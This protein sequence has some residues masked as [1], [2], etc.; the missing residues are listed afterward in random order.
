MLVEFNNIISSI[1]DNAVLIQVENAIAAGDV[2]L[3]IKL[4]GLDEATWQP[5]VEQIRQSYIVGGTTGAGQI[6]SIPIVGGQITMRF[7]GSNPRAENWIKTES[8]ALIVE[9]NNSQKEL[10][11]ETVLNGMI[12]GDNPKTTARDLIGTVN[13]ETGKRVGGVVG[14]TSQQASWL[15]NAKEELKTLD[16]NYFNRELRDKRLDGPIKKAMRDGKKLDANLINKAIKLMG[17]KT[18][19]YRS[20]NIARTESISALRAGQY[21]AIAQGVEAGNIEASD[22]VKKWDATGGHRTRH[23]HNQAERDYSEGIP[24]DQYFIVA[25]E[26]MLYPSDTSGGATG[27]NII[28]CRC[29]LIAEI[30]F[31]KKLARLEGFA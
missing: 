19:I 22:V 18:L 7:N 26:Q 14:L 11:R 24:L 13:K 5:L 3:V 23:W 10:V 17:D 15:K 29:R 12:A 8:S 6:G 30:D 20:E 21:E 9:I 25:N 31:G 1:K 27:K 4:L 16:A 2:D 28:N